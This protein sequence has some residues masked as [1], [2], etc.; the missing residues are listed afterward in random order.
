[1][2]ASADVLGANFYTDTD[3]S[4]AIRVWD[5]TTDA[6]VWTDAIPPDYIRYP[7]LIRV[8]RDGTHFAATDEMYPDPRA[9]TRLYANGAMTAAVPGVAVG[10]SMTHTCWSSATRTLMA[11]RAWPSS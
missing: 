5:I 8:S 10:W 1:M 11:R 6:T 4:Y 7:P 9:T 2:P 3:F